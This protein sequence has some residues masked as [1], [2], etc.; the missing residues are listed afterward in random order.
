MKIEQQ[1]EQ[2]TVNIIQ[3]IKE[4]RIDASAITKDLRIKCVEVLWL[5][6]Y[7][8][9]EMA[10]IFNCSDKTIKRDLNEIREINAITPN[11]EHAKKIIGEF[12]LKSQNSHAYLSKLA[13][14]KDGSLSEKAQAEYSAHSVLSDTIVKLQSLGYLPS[15]EQ[16]V[17]GNIF[18]HYGNND[19]EY[20]K[21]ANAEIAELEEICP[22]NEEI[23]KLKSRADK[24]SNTINA[25]KENE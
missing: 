2:S 6:G 25:N 21:T 18:H 20:L 22:E 4:G 1:N 16:N 11:I 10:Q 9:S 7:K 5:E 23:S 19:M 17:V 12:W 3:S 15:V 8:A 14:S 13:R 24:I